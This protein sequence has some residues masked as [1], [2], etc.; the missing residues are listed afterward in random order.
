MSK[1]KSNKYTGVYYTN[2][3]N[4]DKSYFITYKE[5]NKKIWVKIGLHSAGIR[6]A[7]CYN[8]R[9]EITTKIRLGE[10]LPSIA[11]KNIKSLNEISRMYYDEK[12]LHNKN[13][14]KSRSRFIKHFSEV[15]GHMTLDK[16]SRTDILD[17]QKEK[18]KEFSPT[19][20]NYILTQLKSVYKWATLNEY[21]NGKN[22]CDNIS[23][24]KLDNKRVR[25]LE[26]KEIKQ[27]K[28][29]IGDEIYLLMFLMIALATGG[30]LETICNI[31]V[32][33]IKSNGNVELY[34]FK[35]ESSYIGFINRSLLKQIEGFIESEDKQENDF[36]L[37]AT[38]NPDYTS[39]YYQ[40]KFKPVFDKLFN[41]NLDSKDSKNRVVIHTL[42]HTFASH[43][44]INEAPI[45]T[46]Q[47]LMNHKDIESTMIYAKLSKNSGLDYVNTITQRIIDI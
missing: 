13:N 39:R 12:S 46:I 6:E 5:N 22:P 17:I 9:N 27:I 19:T 30:R 4:K 20:V 24:I 37:Q 25:Y 41:Q 15:I 40:R 2:L 44:A 28:D 18:V 34:D 1:I 43:L 38:S 31:K 8:K 47:K 14:E 10:D 29:E 32:K 16:I 33:N 3:E 23:S 45:L 21:Y 42:R 36:L 7:Y 35:N 11:K 26:L